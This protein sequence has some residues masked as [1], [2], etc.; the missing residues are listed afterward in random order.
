MQR[1]ISS[2][3]LVM[4]L[5]SVLFISC[6][7]NKKAT[8]SNK[9]SDTKT[10][11]KKSDSEKKNSSS[12]KK[13][14]QVIKAARSYT[15]TPYK[16]GGTSKAGI[17]CSGLTSEAYKSIGVLLPRTAGDQSNFGKT[18]SLDN[19]QKGDL[20]FF[21]DKKG[22]KKVTHVGMVTEVRGKEEVKFIHASTKVGVVEADLFST[23]YKPLVL[24][25]VRVF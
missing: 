17:D 6:K 12:G 9:S 5:C 11:T 10:S 24:K 25:A 19:L 13:P 22:H 14:E 4:L 18:V 3:F 23:Y 2:T 16:Y 8:S 7:S 15:G 20:V 21:T 1:F